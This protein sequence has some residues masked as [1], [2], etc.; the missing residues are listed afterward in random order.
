MVLVLLEL[1]IACK[2]TDCDVITKC[3]VWC[4]REEIDTLKENGVGT[5][6]FK[7]DG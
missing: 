7:S 2:R 5:T 4:D 6:D 3:D 1:R